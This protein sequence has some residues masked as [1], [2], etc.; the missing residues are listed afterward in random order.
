MATA[1]LMDTLDQGLSKAQAT[2]NKVRTP[3][4]KSLPATGAPVP[5]AP[6]KRKMTKDW[7]NKLYS[8][9]KPYFDK[10][11]FK[12]ITA[13]KTLSIPKYADWLSVRGIEVENCWI[14]CLSF[15]SPDELLAFWRAQGSPALSLTEQ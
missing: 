7:L 5:F 9:H 6:A 10:S 8:R 3:T 2:L 11:T 14:E 15:P 12:G 4:I 1:R 13:A